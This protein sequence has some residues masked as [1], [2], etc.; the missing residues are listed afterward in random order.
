MQNHIGDIAARHR[1]RDPLTDKEDD[2]VDSRGETKEKR[3]KRRKRRIEGTE[4]QDCAVISLG[5]N[6]V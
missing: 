5:A 4:R 3:R 1:D 2:E 6:L